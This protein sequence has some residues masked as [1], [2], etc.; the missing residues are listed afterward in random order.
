MKNK[1][2]NRYYTIM[3]NWHRAK[4]ES[5]SRRGNVLEMMFHARKENVYA[6]K[7]SELTK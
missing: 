3:I 2:L 7:R 5:A 1:I 6:R 4:I